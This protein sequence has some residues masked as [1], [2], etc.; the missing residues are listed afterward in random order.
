MA[1]PFA[2]T[3]GIYLLAVGLQLLGRCLGW[4]HCLVR[5][6]VQTAVVMVIY[7]N[8]AVARSGAS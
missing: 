4:I 6:A 1:V 8:E 5:T 3:G 7:L 2:L